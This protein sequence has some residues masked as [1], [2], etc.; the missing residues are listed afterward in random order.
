[1][2]SCALVRYSHNTAYMPKGCKAWQK[3]VYDKSQL[4]ILQSIKVYSVSIFKTRKGEAEYI[5]A[6]DAI[7]RLW[8]V[9][10][11]ERDVPTRFGSTHV[12][13]SGPSKA[14][15]LV[16]LHGSFGSAT[17]WYLGVADLSRVYRTYA[18]DTIGDLGKSV[19]RQLPVKRSDYVEWLSD[20]FDELG[21]DQADIVGI[22]FGGS[23]ALKFA[24]AKPER[25][26]RLALLGPGL[27]LL[28][29]PTLLWPFYCLLVMVHP[30]P[31]TVRLYM[32][33]A[34]VNRYE[35]N[36]P[37]LLQRIK[38]MIN[39]HFRRRFPSQLKFTKVELRNLKA[40]AL[41]LIGDNEVL[42]DHESALS[43]A[44]RLIPNLE[45]EIV[46][47]SGHALI[48]DQPEVVN[49]RI[50]LFLKDRST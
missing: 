7:L 16:L 12:I 19:P 6:Y 44:R 35:K 34:S 46:P 37:V 25:V 1:M 20:A 9:P 8:P 18:L 33:K 4:C 13:V 41:L 22:S 30:S 2:S 26:K 29:P 49:S 14:Q 39:L 27:R 11:V 40:P 10:C 47:D 32:Q 36:D 5:A 28:G 17:T 50:L 3:H 43:Q 15:P 24:L 38:G 45:A 21:I 48:R 31:R 23:L 42:Y